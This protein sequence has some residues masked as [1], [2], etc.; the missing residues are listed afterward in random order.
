MSALNIQ[1]LQW[2]AAG[3]EPAAWPLFIAWLSALWGAW[4]CA[5]ALAWVAWKRRPERGYLA[6]V[7]A[8]AILASLLSHAIAAHFDV[9][10]PFVAGWVPAYISHRASA[11]TPSTHA[12][13]MFFIAF[14]LLFREGLRRLGGAMLA[15]ACIVGWARIYV[16]VHFPLDILAG[17]TLAAAQAGLLSLAWK[18]FLPASEAVGSRPGQ[19][20]HIASTFAALP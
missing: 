19:R 14:A 13:V 6:T 20:R 2:M 1:C 7:V 16:G 18:Q 4:A 8:G 3:D 10:R 15:L 9:P 12:T 17:I 5:A 11:A